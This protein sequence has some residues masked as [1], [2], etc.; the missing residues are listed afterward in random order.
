MKHQEFKHVILLRCMSQLLTQL[1]HRAAPNNMR[2]K[3]LAP[4]PECYSLADTMPGL[5]P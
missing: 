4:F 5:D 3:A 1:R 2:W